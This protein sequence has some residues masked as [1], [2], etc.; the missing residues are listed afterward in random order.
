MPELPGA[1][2]DRLMADYG[3][4][5]YDAKVLTSSLE[6]AG[7]YEAAVAIAGRSNAKICANWV[8]VDLA[9]RLNKE[10]REIGDS[11]VSAEQ[12][13]GLIARIADGTI[14]TNMAR[15]VFDTLWNGEGGS[16]DDIIA[17]QGLQQITDQHRWKD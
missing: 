13:G 9:A 3:L 6:L 10:E 7:Y 1:K 15:K 4:S 12:L 8:M 5:L 2:R 17:S 16:A 14:S 11:P